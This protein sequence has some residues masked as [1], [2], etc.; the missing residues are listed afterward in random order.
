MQT[1]LAMG[2]CSVLLG[3]SLGSVQ[4]M[5]MSSLH[6]M[7]P[8]NRHGEAVAM[9]MMTIN[10]SSVIM[11][12]LFGLTG[13]L[14]GIAGLFWLTGAAVGGGTR[15]AFKLDAASGATGDKKP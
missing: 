14:I 5:I 3:L 10:A 7:T 8:A 12:I 9:R 6:Q 2:M 4:P 1:P 11:P 15:L 13:S